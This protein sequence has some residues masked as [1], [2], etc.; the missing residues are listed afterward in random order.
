[1]SANVD[2]WG[3]PSGRC[4]CPAGLY[5]GELKMD[6]GSGIGN[7]ASGSTPFA[8]THLDFVCESALTVNALL[9][10]F[11]AYRVCCHARFVPYS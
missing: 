10:Y 8:S 5:T 9:S 7:P 4:H 2:S 11:T 1:M 3:N 6:S